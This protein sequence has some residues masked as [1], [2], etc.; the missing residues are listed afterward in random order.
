MFRVGSRVKFER[1]HGHKKKSL[2]RRIGSRLRILALSLD[3]E[4]CVPLRVF[5][6]YLRVLTNTRENQTESDI[7]AGHTVEGLFFRRDTRA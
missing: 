6:K 7:N 3:R 2:K 1:S 4:N 5:H